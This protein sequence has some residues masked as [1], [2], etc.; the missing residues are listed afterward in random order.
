MP[1]AYQEDPW[2]KMTIFQENEV[3][4]EMLSRVV[5]VMCNR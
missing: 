5:S 3:D 4:F 2:K 1:L